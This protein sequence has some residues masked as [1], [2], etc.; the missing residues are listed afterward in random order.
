MN[1]TKLLPLTT[2][3]P[4]AATPPRRLNVFFCRVNRRSSPPEHHH[5]FLWRES[6]SYF[7][8]VDILLDGHAS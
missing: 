7:L 6:V 4:N 1:F 2:A 8:F 5:Y 3:L